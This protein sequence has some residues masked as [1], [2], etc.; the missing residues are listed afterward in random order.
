MIKFA[1]YPLIMDRPDGMLSAWLD[2]FLPLSDLSLWG[3]EP[4]NYRTYRHAGGADRPAVN[5]GMP[6]M[7]WPPRWKVRLNSLYWPSGATRWAQFVG[8]CDENT[9]QKIL[10]VVEEPTD[11][12]SGAAPTPGDN[13]PAQLILADNDVD[14][15]QIKNDAYTIDTNDLAA[16]S[17]EMYLLPPRLLQSGPGPAQKIYLLPLVDERYWWQYRQAD[18]GTVFQGQQPTPTPNSLW[19]DL[20]QQVGVCDLGAMGL[21]DYNT[22]YPGPDAL[23]W[24]YPWALG[25]YIEAVACT[26]G[27]RVVRSYNKIVSLDNYTDS[28]VTLSKNLEGNWSTIAGGDFSQIHADGGQ[29]G[30]VQVQFSQHPEDMLRQQGGD[31]TTAVQ[32]KQIAAQ[33]AGG[34]GDPNAYKRFFT[35]AHTT[36]SSQ[37]KDFAQAVAEDFYGWGFYNYDYVFGGLKDWKQTGFDDAVEW[38][39]DFDPMGYDPRT[40][41]KGSYNFFTRVQTLPLNCGF[42]DLP[43]TLDWTPTSDVE[44]KLQE[45]LSSKGSAKGM[46]VGPQSQATGGG[47]MPTMTT[48]R[49]VRIWDGMGLCN[50]LPKDTYV[51]ARAIPLV[52]PNGY[53][54]DWGYLAYAA[55]CKCQS[56]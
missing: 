25:P 56:S 24:A 14:P 18:V 31:N 3:V 1:G 12:S 35:T 6:R 17:V 19:L 4:E 48:S 7:N 22:A 9:L 34:A 16:L 15:A 26:I 23:Y 37:A 36:D 21:S 51:L 10:D 47:T 29:P 55:Q 38:R 40:G 13:A 28:G 53:N 41:D 49:V 45:P 11:S 46:I 20:V 30:Y 39:M 33:D 5:V 43:H 52:T 32:Q 27:C 54:R 44:V 42:S 8:I 50:A 2:R